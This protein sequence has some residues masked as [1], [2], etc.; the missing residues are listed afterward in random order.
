MV[1]LARHLVV[2]LVVISAF[3]AV[4]YAWKAI[5]AASL[6]TDH[7]GNRAPSDGSFRQ[8]DQAAKGNHGLSVSNVGDL[9]QSLAI[10]GVVLAGVVI[11]DR[12]RRS[13]RRRAPSPPPGDR[14]DERFTDG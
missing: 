6:V 4:G 3:V 9:I 12:E 7:R 13:R 5:P 2:V 1:K 11:V 10:M 8:P 14:R